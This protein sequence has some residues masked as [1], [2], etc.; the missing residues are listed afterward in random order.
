MRGNFM[1]TAIV[2][3]TSVI[4]GH[5]AV[6]AYAETIAIV[7]TGNVAEALG[8]RFAELGH[9]I[10]YG[11]REPNRTDVQALVQRTGHG[12]RAL[13]P[14][15]AAAA[16]DAIVL[17]IPWDAA[18]AVVSSLGNVSGKV[19]IDPT[20]PRHIAE[21]GLRDYAFTG[22][23]AERIQ[24][25]APE[26]HVVKAF[27]T[28]T[29]GLMANPSSAGGPVTVALAGDDPEAKAF[30]AE[31]AQG[32]GFDTIDFGPVRYAHV[33][34]GMFYVWGN[35]RQTGTP[36]EFFMRRPPSN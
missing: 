11:S 14:A 18:E 16:A 15:A 31:L 24:Q 1:R 7:G 21:D 6:S 9:T 20:N 25:W 29:A 26:A 34:E 8:P 17:A 23:N 30:V 32:I 2:F 33:I 3:L 12:A 13:S 10:I 19:I 5:L 4:L 27:N 22:S 36:F 35:A 28:M